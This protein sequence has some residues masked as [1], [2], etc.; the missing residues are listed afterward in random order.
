MTRDEEIMALLAVLEHEGVL[1]DLYRQLGE[2][3][4]ARL[5]EAHKAWAEA[6]LHP[7]VERP[8]R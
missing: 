2:M 3:D 5:A 4:R 6:R 8:D 7:L 1:A